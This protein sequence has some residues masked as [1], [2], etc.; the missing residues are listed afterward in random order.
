MYQRNCTNVCNELRRIAMNCDELRWIAMN[1]DELQWNANPGTLL[2]PKTK[3]PRSV[4]IEISSNK[5]DMA[6]YIKLK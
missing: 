4:S 3:I 1:C 6:W 5:L 2:P